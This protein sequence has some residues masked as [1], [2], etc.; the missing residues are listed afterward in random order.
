MIVKL[1]MGGLTAVRGGVIVRLVVWHKN[2][3]RS[4]LFLLLMPALSFAQTEKK[5]SGRIINVFS[6][7]LIILPDRDIPPKFYEIEET[8]SKIEN[9]EFMVD[10]NAA[11][12][13]LLYTLFT[14]DQ[15]YVL[16][17]PKAF[18]IDNTSTAIF[19]DT[20][21]WEKSYVKGDVGDEFEQ[22]FTPF[23]SENLLKN[24][25]YSLY[26][27][28]FVKDVKIDTALY[29]YSRLHPDS[30][31]PLWFLIKRYYQFGHSALRENHLGQFSDEIKDS[32]IWK[33]LQED[34]D[35]ALLKQGST[36]PTMK[37]LDSNLE[38]Y[39]LKDNQ[40][41]YFLLDFWFTSC[42]PCIQALPRLNNIYERFHKNGL[43]I[44]SISVDRD[45]AVEKWR[46]R[47]L[48]KDMPWKHCLDPNGLK[49]NELFVKNFPRYILLDANWNVV[50]MD[51]SLDEL[52]AYLD[53]YL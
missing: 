52:E 45:Q 13:Q 31:I 4:I 1:T 23:I 37:L 36:F 16:N 53:Y 34:M 2:M 12:P 35:R 6:D 28:P 18:F 46:S 44:I 26:S 9:E 27:M 32:K 38:S 40:G 51:I 29:N 25:R 49:S 11:Y 8:R 41:K 7:T 42:K 15:G 17:R 21:N 20:A 10:V 3:I 5:I 19:I 43:E 22:Q 50:N 39:S 33:L 47:I 48:E 24:E 30:F 14:R